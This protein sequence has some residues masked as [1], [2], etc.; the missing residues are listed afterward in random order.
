MRL[1]TD[2]MPL[3]EYDQLRVKKIIADEV[4]A[5]CYDEA[6]TGEFLQFNEAV[7]LA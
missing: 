7:F 4:K 1:D 6:L 5:E 2:C 3:L